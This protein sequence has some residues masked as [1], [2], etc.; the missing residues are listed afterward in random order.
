MISLILIKKIFS[1]FI[2]IFMGYAVV[3]AG[4][5]R[6]E[7][8]KIISTLTAYVIFPCIML[9]AF[10][11]ERSPEIVR[12]LVLGLVCAA[13]LCLIP[14]VLI[15]LL[16]KPLRLSAT[17][18][19]TV[20]YPNTGNLVVALVISIMGP[21]YVIYTSPFMCLHMFLMWSHGKAIISGES[22]FDLKKVLSNINMI[23][24]IIGF[25]LFVAGVTLPQPVKEA[26]DGV[27]NMTGPIVM[28]VTGMLIADMSKEK[29]LSYKRLPFVVALRLLVIP[30]IFVPIYRFI[31]GLPMAIGCE[32]V[33]LISMI[34]AST[35]TA[36]TI[37]QLSQL[38]GGDADYANVITLVGT[39]LCI[40]TVPLM[41]AL[42]QL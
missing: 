10:T 33:M 15:A 37:T 22:K 2:I 5:L 12:G 17:E 41:V 21:E 40:V 31:S 35:P 26:I 7:D 11:V 32:E 8:S 4:V 27:G 28:L 3:K 9:S 38:F 18:Q 39:V 42:Y 30:L 25:I 23:A 24:I 13:L 19:V 6:T 34:S 14:I 29:L 1:L 36:I 16:K 20:I